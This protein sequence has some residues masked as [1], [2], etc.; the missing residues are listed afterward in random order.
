MYHLGGTAYSRSG[1][2]DYLE[3]A[4]PGGAKTSDR[5]YA[6]PPDLAIKAP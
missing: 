5:G 2:S 3:R 1:M 6:V 4:S